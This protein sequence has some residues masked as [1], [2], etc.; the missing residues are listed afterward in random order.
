MKPNNLA[1]VIII[2][3][4]MMAITSV[5]HAQDRIER[6]GDKEY[7]QINDEWFYLTEQAD[8]VR[9]SPE[10]LIV[11]L[12]E[13]AGEIAQ[14]KQSLQLNDL[15]IVSGPTS[16]G[17]Y[18]LKS[19]SVNRG[20]ELN[21]IFS[22]HQDIKSVMFSEHGEWLS[23]PND[24][25]WSNQW[26]LPKVDMPLSWQITKGNPDIVIAVIDSGTQLD[27]EDIEDCLWSGIGYN[28]INP[29]TSPTDNNGHGTSVAGI[30][31][32]KTNN[33]IGIAGVA[34]CWDS[35]S[36]TRLMILKVGDFVPVVEA[37]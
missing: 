6:I 23:I 13:S 2:I 15:E 1:G 28:A 5:A 14:L 20:I 18:V 12:K 31:G 30:T 36:G 37:T 17:Y 16:G 19:P 10:R 24:L 25:F 27:H 3:S 29:G 26:N 7:Q 32:A 4:L 34:G 9:F 21:R 11:R 33:A 8:T 35:N 22:D